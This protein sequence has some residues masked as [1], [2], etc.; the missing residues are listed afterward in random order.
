M[1]LRQLRYFVAT[2]EE[3]HFG[4]A[5]ERVH[6]AQ[7]ALSIQIKALEDTLGV[8]LLSRTNRVVTLT[9]AGRLF[10]KEARRTLEQAQHAAVVAR[11]AGR[12]EIGHI[13]IGYSADTSYSGVLSGV[14]RQY[15]RR[16]PDVE[17]GLHELHP[18]TQ[19]AQLL[20][21]RIHIGFIAS[22]VDSPTGK[23]PPE[24]D[25]IRL[26]EWPLRV[27]LPADHPLAKR[28][29]IP[30][31]A[32]ADEPFIV[33]VGSDIEQDRSLIQMVI[34][35]MP[36]VAYEVRSGFSIVSLVGAGLGVAIV[37]SSV[38]SVSIGEHVVYRPI[39]GNTTQVGTDVVFRRDA[40]D[41]AVVN[42]LEIVRPDQHDI[43]GRR[44]RR[45]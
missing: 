44:H 13:E 31:E 7:P 21:G 2:A 16:V 33:Y 19:I 43:K 17:L 27:A 4:R 6:I 39:S 22:F 9:E 42:F 23:L 3:L 40:D 37:P 38:S 28:S 18:S 1:D 29:R 25:A 45:R 36:R 20:E 12:G 5:A 14:L 41:P 15:K 11:R 8:Q 35:F 10:L 24:L 34:G 32:L 26:A 30:R